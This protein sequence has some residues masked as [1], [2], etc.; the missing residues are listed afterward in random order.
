MD[1]RQLGVRLTMGPGHTGA[2]PQSAADVGAQQ[3]T[4]PQHSVWEGCPAGGGGLS[5]QKFLEKVSDSPRST[6][7]LGLANV[8]EPKPPAVSRLVWKWVVTGP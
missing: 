3:R 2:D 4:A 7:R 5:G 1:C 6:G 8:W